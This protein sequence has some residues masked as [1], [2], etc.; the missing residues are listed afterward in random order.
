MSVAVCVRGS[1]AERRCVVLLFVCSDYPQE[2]LHVRLPTDRPPVPTLDPNL[3][4]PDQGFIYHPGAF[5]Y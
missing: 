5:R 2:P 3:I 4:I 1:D